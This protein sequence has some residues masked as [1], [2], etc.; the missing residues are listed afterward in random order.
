LPK[1]EAEACKVGMARSE[2][3]I[4]PFLPPPVGRMIMSLNPCKMI[5][6]IILFNTYLGSTCESL[7]QKENN[8]VFMLGNLFSLINFD[9]SY[10]Y[11]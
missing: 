8:D 6:S 5:V 10:G 2:P 9:D 3:N 11:E 7:I 4:E 1:F